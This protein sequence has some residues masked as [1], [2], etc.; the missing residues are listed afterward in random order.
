MASNLSFDQHLNVTSFHE[1]GH[2]AILVAFNI[3]IDRFERLKDGTAQ[4]VPGVTPASDLHGLYGRIL[5]VRASRHS[6]K[7]SPYN[8]P[9]IEIESFKTD[10]PEINKQSQ[11]L[12]AM[13]N[14]TWTD[15]KIDYDQFSKELLHVLDEE[16]NLL[17]T[18]K[19]YRNFIGRV[20]SIFMET[21]YMA[22]PDVTKMV[23]EQWNLSEATIL[24]SRY[25][26]FITVCTR[27]PNSTPNS[28]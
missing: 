9:S 11:N 26:D 10:D 13:F 20:A 8:T 5:V 25:S 17:Y 2:A 4:I 14:K 27:Q 23:M 16:L 3:D 21:T 7:C 22:G 6:Q 18:N 1:A 12:Y 19:L 28:I 24:L 15:E